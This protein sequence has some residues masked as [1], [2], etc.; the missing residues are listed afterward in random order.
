MQQWLTGLDDSATQL[1]DFEQNISGELKLKVTN[2]SKIH[3]T[4]CATTAKKTVFPVVVQI[5]VTQGEFLRSG[6]C[7]PHLVKEC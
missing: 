1:H 4:T 2:Y 3:E 6:N 7:M 5:S